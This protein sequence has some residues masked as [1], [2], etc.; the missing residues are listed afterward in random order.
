MACDSRTTSRLE[1]HRIS[2][3]GGDG[4]EEAEDCDGL[5]RGEPA[6]PAVASRLN[7]GRIRR[8]LRARGN[9]NKRWTNIGARTQQGAAH[10]HTHNN[11]HALRPAGGTHLWLPGIVAAV[12]CGGFAQGCL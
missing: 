11:M 9:A 3:A 12:R 7:L 4:Q 8:A 10:L 5:H 2:K 1:P 6:S